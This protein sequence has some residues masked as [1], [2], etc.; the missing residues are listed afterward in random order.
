MS[1]SHPP[2]QDL[3]VLQVCPG[4]TEK[5]GFKPRA[6]T[7]APRAKSCL[8][9]LPCSADCSQGKA[10]APPPSIICPFMGWAL[11]L[12]PGPSPKK[13]ATPA[14]SLPLPGFGLFWPTPYP[15]RL[16]QVPPPV[17]PLSPPAPRPGKCSPGSPST[18][19]TPHPEPPTLD[20]LSSLGI[21]PTDCALG[22]QG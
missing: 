5:S 1:V 19:R 2:G 16:A 6:G 20:G 9:D 7:L 14:A 13:A 11:P 17:V 22:G 3:R 10:P 15:C 18:V 21:S 12:S 4:H 8:A